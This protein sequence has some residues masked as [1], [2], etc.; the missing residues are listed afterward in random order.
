[1]PPASPANVRDQST[2]PAGEYFRTS[3]AAPASVD[4]CIQPAATTSPRRSTAIPSARAV[5]GLRTVSCHFG[6]PSA[7]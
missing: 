2:S 5:A 7:A 6:V 4:F 1:M 3:Q